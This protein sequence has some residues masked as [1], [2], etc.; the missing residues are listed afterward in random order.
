MSVSH[1][2]RLNAFYIQVKIIQ[3]RLS[4]KANNIC[5]Q[6]WGRL[7]VTGNEI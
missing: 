1:E 7:W 3:H 5:A 2:L 6:N 4:L